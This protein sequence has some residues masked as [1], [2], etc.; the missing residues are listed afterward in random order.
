VIETQ[1]RARFR[2]PRFDDYSTEGGQAY[3]Y[4]QDLRQ[5]SDPV[6]RVVDRSCKRRW[7]DAEVSGLVLALNGL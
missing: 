6:Q 7:L 5:V 3:C 2:L 4:L 1:D